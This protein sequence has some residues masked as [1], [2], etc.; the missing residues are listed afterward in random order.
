MKK[1]YFVICPVTA[2]QYKYITFLKVYKCSVCPSSTATNN[3]YRD[4]VIYHNTLLFVVG[5]SSVLVELLMKI[6][7]GQWRLVEE[8][9]K[10][11]WTD[12]LM[13][14]LEHVRPSK[15]NRLVETGM[16]FV[17]E[18]WGGVWGC[19]CM[20]VDVCMCAREMCG[21]YVSVWSIDDVTNI[22][23]GS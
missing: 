9:F 5:T 15:R 16:Y 20:S 1:S 22:W 21:V 3:K 14:C 17:C 10:L 8:P 11:Q 23:Q 12:S 18:G 19:V 7:D 2:K 4:A 13:V 6:F